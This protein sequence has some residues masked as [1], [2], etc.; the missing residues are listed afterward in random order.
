MMAATRQN[1]YTL[2]RF[3]TSAVTA[4]A[5]DYTLFLFLLEIG[6][7]WYLLASFV[8]LVFGGITAF[9]LER[10]WTFKRSDGKLSGQAMRF[11]LVWISS[12]LLNTAGLYF[13]V[14]VFG[15]QYIIGKVTVSVIVGIG[16]NFF[17]HKHFVFR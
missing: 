4:T 5:V 2:L 17:M 14:T 10:S 11:L 8:G 1:I 3:N 12:I 15:F 6:H 16:F 9:L 13:I 7:V